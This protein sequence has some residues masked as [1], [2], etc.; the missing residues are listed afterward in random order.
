MTRR[1]CNLA[2]VRPPSVDSLANSIRASGLPHQLRVEAARR[3]IANN[4]HENVSTYARDIYDDLL[5]PVING[6]GVIIHTNLGRSPMNP[7]RTY[8]TSFRYSNLELDL[9]HG[10]RG[11]R[12][13]RVGSQIAGYIGAESA[14]IVNNGA[15]AILLVL[16]ALAFDRNVLI[17]RGELV[18][19]GG[20]FRIPEVLESAGA[21]LI[22]VGTT[23]KTRFRDYE[24]AAKD[25]NA[26]AILKVHESNYRMIGFTENVPVEKLKTLGLPVIFDI[27]SGLLD[28]TV[29]WMGWPKPSWLKDEPGA[30]QTIQSGASIVTFSGDKLMGG[31]QAGI[32]AGKKDFVE[33]CASHPLY[34]ALRPGN[35]TL[36]ALGETLFAY[37]DNRAGQLPLWKMAKTSPEELRKRAELMGVGRIVKLKSAIGGGSL[38]G[39]EIDSYGIAL[40]GDLTSELR[41]TEIPIIA[42]MKGPDTVIDLRTVDAK[43]D[44]YLKSALCEFD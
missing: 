28:D 31:P 36:D 11:S 44:A 20:G 35:L 43:D 23:N 13:K 38:P 15:A 22:E 19:I 1:A 37:L 3:S 27:G 17:S 26:V 4:D 34:R 39:Q 2:L 10:K 9:A 6:T 24:N 42:R 33:T 25:S 30:R 29:P 41:R 12:D 7:D 40:K 21:H 5:R 32:I 18:E 14:I 8:P 16:T